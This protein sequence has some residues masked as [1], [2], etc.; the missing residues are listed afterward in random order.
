MEIKSAIFERRSTRSF[1]NRIP[2]AE[3]VRYIL[4]AAINAP[5]ACNL[6][7]WHFYCVTDPEVR[8]SFSE[9]AENWVSTA[10]VIFVICT[11]SRAIE[12]R[13]GKSERTD[14]F[15]I[16]D[17]ALAMENMLLAAVDLGLGGC[18]IGAYDQN[19]CREVLNIPAEHNPVAL[20]PI[21]EPTAK[22]PPRV[23]KPMGEVVTFV[24]EVP[25]APSQPEEKTPFTLKNAW[26]PGSVFDD[27]G[28][29]DSTF[30][31]VNMQ[32]ARFT[33]INMQGASFGNM[34]FKDSSFSGLYMNGVQFE[35]VELKNA[36]FDSCDLSGATVDGIDILDALEKA[37]SEAE[38]LCGKNG[39]SSAKNVE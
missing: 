27:L 34:D 37:K 11:D 17:T 6:Q 19:K 1:T 5:S 23:R 35:N 28:M 20:L 33:D 8:K 21:G 2:T 31:N 9:F 39:T 32:N 16:Q 3:E 18:I 4:E 30:N 36:R 15:V 10:P 12:A 38:S 7:S 29:P 14:K 25:E 22:I 24:G 13:F 26:L